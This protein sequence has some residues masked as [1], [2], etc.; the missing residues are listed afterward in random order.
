MDNPDLIVTC[1]VGDGEAETGPTAAAWHG[2]KYIDP[3]ESGAVLPIL[4]LNGFKISERTIFGTMDDKELVS[5]Y[6]YVPSISLLLSFY[7]C[8]VLFSGYGYQTRIVCDL[9]DLDNDLAASLSWAITEIHKI[10]HAARTGN[11]IVKP[12]WPVI[13]LRTPKGLSA[14]QHDPEGQIIEG[15]FHSHQ[16]PLPK[17]KTDV[18][19]LRL[20]NEWLRG[21]NPKELFQVNG[22]PVEAIRRLIPTLD[23]KKLG[24]KRESYKNYVPLVSPEWQPLAVE[25]GS[26][27]SGMTRVGQYLGEVIDA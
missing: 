4:H 22:A 14:P 7:S 23:D 8:I 9:D 16:V 25:K 24:Q 15:S 13:I 6:E 27:E 26:Q 19:H 18:R 17:A 10:Q 5:L 3:A 12:R 1:V 2:F 21:Y 11:P 20:L